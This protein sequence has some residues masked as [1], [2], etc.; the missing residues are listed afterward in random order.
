LGSV[1][2]FDLPSAIGARAEAAVASALV[3]AG[4]AVFVPAFA[5]HERVDLVYLGA[6]RPV[7]VQCKAARVAGGVVIFKTCSYTANRPRAYTDEIDEF[8]VYALGTGLVYLVPSAGLPIRE[9]T[10]RLEPVRNGQA[11]GIRWAAD[12]LLGPP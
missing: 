5:A 4:R 12:Y 11:A 7:R 3:R 8:G 9:C 1:D 10:L 6:E 2:P